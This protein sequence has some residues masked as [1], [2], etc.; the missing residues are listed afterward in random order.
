MRAG[1]ELFSLECCDMSQTLTY[2]SREGTAGEI[3]IRSIQNLLNLQRLNFL[4]EK[5]NGS[6]VGEAV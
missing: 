2:V 3:L 6:A 4:F 1:R 5:Q